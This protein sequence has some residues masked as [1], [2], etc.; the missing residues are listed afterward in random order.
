MYKISTLLL[1]LSLTA[2]AMTGSADPLMP[3]GPT[4][5]T[6]TQKQNALIGR[7]FSLVGG[8]AFGAGLVSVGFAAESRS[9]VKA[10]FMGVGVDYA[11]A[12]IIPDAAQDA[13]GATPR[14]GAGLEI[15]YINCKSNTYS[16]LP[17]PDADDLS[18]AERSWFIR[19]EQNKW[20]SEA[21][22][23]G[24]GKWIIEAEYGVAPELAKFFADVCE[25]TY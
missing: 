15:A 11:K 18:N 22:R 12:T 6:I 2:A 4:D 25:A 21:P 10:Y 8:N 3:T 7:T 20:T 24:S 14:R 17:Y 5:A 16:A 19:G 1:G 9:V 23:D 13:S